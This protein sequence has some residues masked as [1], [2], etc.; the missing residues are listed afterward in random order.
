M[1]GFA[2]H[3]CIVSES[4]EGMCSGTFYISPSY[5]TFCQAAEFPCHWKIWNPT[6]LDVGCMYI[7]FTLMEAIWGQQL[8]HHHKKKQRRKLFQSF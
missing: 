7:F 6:T 3:F 2:F 1:L 4:T 8:T 5:F